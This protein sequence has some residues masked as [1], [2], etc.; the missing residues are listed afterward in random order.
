M[1]KFAN[2]MSPEITN[3]TFQLRENHYNVRHSCLFIV[4]LMHSAYNGTKT[5][6]CLAFKQRTKSW[7]P[8][9]YPCRL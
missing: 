8:N 3:E 6:I 4:S 7:K 9:N 2:G 5:T 1:C